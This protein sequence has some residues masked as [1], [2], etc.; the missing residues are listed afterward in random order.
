[1]ADVA[2][3]KGKASHCGFTSPGQIDDEREALRFE[4]SDERLFRSRTVAHARRSVEIQAVESLP[5]QAG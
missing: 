4:L 1:M 2:G 5:L 3:V